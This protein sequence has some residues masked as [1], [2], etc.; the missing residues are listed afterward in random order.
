[1][2]LHTITHVRIT[3]RRK[4]L[5]PPP[6]ETMRK[7]VRRIQADWKWTST[8]ATRWKTLRR[9]NNRRNNSGARFRV[10]GPRVLSSGREADA[11]PERRWKP[12]SGYW[13]PEEINTIPQRAWVTN[14]IPSLPR[15]PVGLC[16]ILSGHGRVSSGAEA[17]IS[18]ASSDALIVLCGLC[19]D[20][21]SFH[22]NGP[23]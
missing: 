21:R 14:C 23:E 18:R 19:A 13:Q 22:A 9:R 3:G 7:S 2:Q 1:M 20:E 4:V 15:N 5:H 17:W 12:P 16:R 11:F 10:G 6:D 8:A